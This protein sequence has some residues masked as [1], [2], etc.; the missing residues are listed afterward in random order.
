M[1]IEE[2]KEINDIGRHA[3]QTVSDTELEIGAMQ[4]KYKRTDEKQA[5]QEQV[6]SEELMNE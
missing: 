1:G 2:A 6:K 4:A 3:I 5:V